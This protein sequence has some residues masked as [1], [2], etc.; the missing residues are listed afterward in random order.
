[1]NEITHAG[2]VFS[3]D[4]SRI[5]SGY[6]HRYLSERSYW[7]QNIAL[8]TVIASIQNSYCAGVYK[9]GHQVGFGRLITDYATFGYLA[10]VF[11]EESHRGKALGKKLV[12]FI[13]ESDVISGLR[14]VMLGTKDAHDLYTKFGFTQL[15]NPQAFM[16]IHRPDIYQKTPTENG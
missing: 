9:G 5:D 1:M 12:G 2:Y 14:R 3:S 6:V 11:I 7:A 8:D 16:E 13:L 10:D 15:K 4:K